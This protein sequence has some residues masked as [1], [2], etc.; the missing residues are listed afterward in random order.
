M[1][2]ILVIALLAA[3]CVLL[4]GCGS[5]SKKSSSTTASSAPVTSASDNAIYE[6]AFTECSSTPI[7]QLAGKYHVATTTPANIAHAVGAGWSDRFHGGS[8]G[9]AIGT[10]GCHDGLAQRPDSSTSA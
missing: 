9:T 8:K 10:S 3:A 7:K 6:R 2:P 1:K 5:S 4:A